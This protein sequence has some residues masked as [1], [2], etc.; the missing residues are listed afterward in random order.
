MKEKEK[1]MIVEASYD[2]CRVERD[3][4]KTI[5]GNS[6]FIL[7]CGNVVVCSCT[8][9]HTPMFFEPTQDKYIIIVY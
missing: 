6:L 9:V 2:K 8:K 5:Y 3:K 7:V 1:V 4:Y